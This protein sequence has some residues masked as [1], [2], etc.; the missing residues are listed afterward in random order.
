[1]QLRMAARN[2]LLITDA[3]DVQKAPAFVA[4]MKNEGSSQ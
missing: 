2:F 4:L 1:M 3:E